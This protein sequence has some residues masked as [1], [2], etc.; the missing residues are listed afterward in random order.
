MTDRN[1]LLRLLYHPF[2]SLVVLGCSFC[3]FTVG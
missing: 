1:P 3:L 2:R